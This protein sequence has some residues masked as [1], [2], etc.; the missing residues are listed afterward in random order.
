M[1][2]PINGTVGGSAAQ[3]VGTNPTN[4]ALRIGPTSELI[5]DELHGRYYETTVRKA[6][7]S[8]ANL[9]GVT[10]TA[11]FATT[12]T[13]MC[14]SNPIGS[15]VN[16]VLTKVTYAPVVAQTAAL[17]MGIMT[18][19]SAATNVTHT[20]PLVPLSNFVGQPAGTG[21][22]DSSATLPVAPTRLILLG[23]LTT[24]AITQTLLNGSVTDME[25]SVVIPPGGY[26]AIY[27]SAASVASSLAFG[28]MWEEVS[29]TI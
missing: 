23:T 3:A 5:V 11:A 19:Y 4:L 2:L 22:I 28:M 6:M 8:G 18:G 29:T 26:A 24:G 13:G 1:A 27:T 15:T 21:L 16:L 9:T 20:T 17:V 14:L 25:G 12:Y 10:T 7:F